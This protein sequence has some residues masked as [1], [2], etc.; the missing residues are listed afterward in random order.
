LVMLAANDLTAAGFFLQ[1]LP[2]ADDKDPDGWSRVEHLARTLKPAELLSLDA[3]TILTRLYH[4][5]TVRIFAPQAVRHDYPPNPEKI[6]DM[7]RALGKEE[8]E[9]ILADEGA[10]HVRDDLSN[11]DYHLSADEARAVFSLGTLH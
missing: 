6:H 4:D 5:E 8:V 7:L 11:H 9:R 3:Q 10:I 1:K 2:S